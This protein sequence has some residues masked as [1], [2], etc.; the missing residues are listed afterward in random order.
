MLNRTGSGGFL[1]KLK[2]CIFKNCYSFSTFS[3]FLC[4]T[5]GELEKSIAECIVDSELET[6]CEVV[7]R[8]KL[9]LDN[10]IQEISTLKRNVSRT[11]Q[12]YASLK[13]NYEV[14]YKYMYGCMYIHTSAYYISLKKKKKYFEK[15]SKFP[16][17]FQLEILSFSYT[18]S[19]FPLRNSYQYLF[20]FLC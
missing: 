4:T 11:L 1:F 14:S 9:I 20:I 18:F 13:R 10:E 5:T 3:L 19:Y 15:C 16:P 2:N 12:E 7:R 6:E 8:L 17:D